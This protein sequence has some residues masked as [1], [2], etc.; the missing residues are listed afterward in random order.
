[1][2]LANL[3]AYGDQSRIHDALADRAV[4]AIAVDHPIY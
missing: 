1:V 2:R 4:D 3:I